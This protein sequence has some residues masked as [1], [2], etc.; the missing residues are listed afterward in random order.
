MTTV[1]SPQT[2]LCGDEI[3]AAVIDIGDSFSRFGTA[4]QDLPRHIL[5]TNVGYTTEDDSNRK[6]LVGDTSLRFIKSNMEIV[7]PYDK[8]IINWDHIEAIFEHGLLDKG[9]KV[10]STDYP[11]MLCESI[12]TSSQNKQKLLEILYE[13][14]S[15]PATYFMANAAL[16]S[17][18]AGRSNSLVIDVG[19]SSIRITPVIDGYTCKR[20]S[21][22]TNRG[23]NWM[24]SLVRQ[25]IDRRLILNGKVIHPWYELD[26]NKTVTNKITACQSYRDYHVKDIVRDVK[27]WMCFVPY[28]PLLPELR[29]EYYNNKVNLPIYELPDG[30][31][32]AHSDNLC[33]IPEKLFISNNTISK[34][35]NKRVR[36]NPILG[37]PSHNQPFEIN[38]EID[39]LQ[40]LVYHSV[41]KCDV[42]IRKELLSNIIVVGGGATID[43]MTQRL[44]YELNEIVT[45]NYKARA[46]SQLNIEKI[47]SSWIGGSILSICGTFQQL[48]L[49]KSEYEEHGPSIVES[50]FIC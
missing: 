27:Q 23:G 50:K 25:E 35:S 8:D 29:S 41:G 32:I 17:F 2:M 46:V 14:M 37:Q 10:D 48:W 33:S 13:K 4:G 24:D 20:A 45:S 3:R 43:G 40:D 6:Y 19:S 7:K 1:I 44:I 15:T 47:N 21:I 36:V 49:S 42:D 30:S 16:S 34:S 28:V 12:F 22:S 31:I 38:P 26:G 11:L 18:S 5:K 9:M 39:N